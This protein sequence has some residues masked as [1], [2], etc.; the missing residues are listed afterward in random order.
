MGVN[1]YE[2]FN[3]DFVQPPWNPKNQNS[4]SQAS[5]SNPQA[6]MVTIAMNPPLKGIT[7]YL[8]SGTS[9]H[10]TPNLSD[11]HDPSVYSGP[12]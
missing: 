6:N 2:H 12:D 7:W 1:C 11:V 5:S 9:H 8:D 4:N 3:K 10:I